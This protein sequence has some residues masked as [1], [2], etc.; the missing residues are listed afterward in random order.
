MSMFEINFCND[1]R[2]IGVLENENQFEQKARLF[3]IIASIEELERLWVGDS[4]SDK[5]Y[6]NDCSVLIQKFKILYPSLEATVP[7]VATFMRR[8]GTNADMAVN[9]CREGAPATGSISNSVKKKGTLIIF[10]TVHNF[11]TV[12]DAIKL[13]MRAV[14]EIYPSINLLKESLE[15]E[16]GILPKKEM[17]KILDWVDKIKSMKA[18]ET[19]SEE[20]SRQL[21]FDLENAYNLL[22]KSLKEN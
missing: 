3:S 6:T 14:D 4:I 20:D 19:I 21:L 9:R 2:D 12:M 22:H 17:G 13:D 16:K 8:Y 15:K 11:I 5:D 10:E 7:T 1:L 18:T